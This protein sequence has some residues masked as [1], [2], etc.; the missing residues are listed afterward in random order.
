MDEIAFTGYPFEDLSSNSFLPEFLNPIRETQHDEC[1]FL[2][3]LTNLVKRVVSFLNDDWTRNLEDDDEDEHGEICEAMQFLSLNGT[4]RFGI[5][6]IWV[7][8][9]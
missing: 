9:S 8:M 6:D 2:G 7:F 5:V 3:K 1:L 4:E